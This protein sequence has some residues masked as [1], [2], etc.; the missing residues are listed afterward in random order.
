MHTAHSVVEFAEPWI[1]VGGHNMNA[2]T[3]TI[4]NLQVVQQKVA[5]PCGKKLLTSCVTSKKRNKEVTQQN[6]GKQKIQNKEEVHR[7]LH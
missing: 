1:G 4:H 7:F 6:L 2:L 3:L 5:L